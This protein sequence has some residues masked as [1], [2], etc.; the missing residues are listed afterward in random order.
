MVITLQNHS[1]IHNST[2]C[3]NMAKPWHTLFVLFSKALWG[4]LPPIEFQVRAVPCR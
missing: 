3:L 2:S 4:T 1:G